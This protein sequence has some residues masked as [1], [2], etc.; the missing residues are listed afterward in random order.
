LF[1]TKFAARL[2]PKSADAEKTERARQPLGQRAQWIAGYCVHGPIGVQFELTR[3]HAHTLDS[4]PVRRAPYAPQAARLGSIFLRSD[5]ITALPPP[6][7]LAG[8][9]Y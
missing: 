3:T 6:K 2:E 1:S 9:G 4:A 5:L 7:S 8:A